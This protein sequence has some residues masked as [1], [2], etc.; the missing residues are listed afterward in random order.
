MRVGCACARAC[1]P[2][3]LPA[4][5]CVRIGDGQVCDLKEA[6]DG[7]MEMLADPLS[8][9]VVRNRGVC[10]VVTDFQ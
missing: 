7:V 8:L 10:S 9:A 4:H 2:A 1:L 6:L 5:A 3:C